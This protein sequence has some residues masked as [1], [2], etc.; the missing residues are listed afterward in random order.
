M[1]KFLHFFRDNDDHEIKI[2]VYDTVNE[3]TTTACPEFFLHWRPRPKGR[4]LRAGWG[5]WGGGSYPISTS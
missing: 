1:S 2:S 3:W 5:S 4:R